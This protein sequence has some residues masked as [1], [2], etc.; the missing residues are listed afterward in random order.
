MGVAKRSDCASDRSPEAEIENV[1]RKR[2]RKRKSKTE[3]ENVSLGAPGVH[4][5]SSL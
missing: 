5:R 3:K 4:L 1:K 2:K